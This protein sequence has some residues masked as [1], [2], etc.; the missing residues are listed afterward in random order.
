MSREFIR[1]EERGGHDDC[2][3]SLR[4]KDAVNNKIVFANLIHRSTD[5]LTA[6]SSAEANPGGC[7]KHRAARMAVDISLFCGPG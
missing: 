1:L 7:G 2:Q 6:F 5:I 4:E 3:L